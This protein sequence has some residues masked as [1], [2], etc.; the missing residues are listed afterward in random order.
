MITQDQLKGIGTR[1]DALYGYLEIEAKKMQIE[2]EDLKTQDP[3]FWTKPKEAEALLKKLK[4]RHK[5]KYIIII[6]TNHLKNASWLDDSFQ[7][8]EI[9]LKIYGIIQ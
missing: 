8:S 3:E 6:N 9:S 5:V 2:E 7:T 1:L 4:Q